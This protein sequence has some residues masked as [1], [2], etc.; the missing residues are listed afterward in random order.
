MN[1]KKISFIMC[2]NDDYYVRECYQYL[3]ELNVPTGYEVEICEIR[4]AR[5]MAAGYNEGM[6][7]TDAKY[8]V[9]LHQDVFIIHKNFLIDMLQLFQ[10]DVGI[11]MIGMVGTPYMFK[12]GVMWNGVRYGSFYRLREY[13]KKDITHRFFPMETGYMEMEAVDGLLIATQ[14]DLPWREDLFQKW[15]FYDASQSFEFIKEGYKVVVPGQDPEWYI[16]DCGAPNLTNYEGERRKFM[17]A[18]KDVM[19]SRQ[20]ETWESYLAHTRERLEQGFH[21]T[22]LEKT[23]ILK[24]LENLEDA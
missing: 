6:H 12:D 18:Y 14:Y 5:S 15:D 11:G 16:H 2:C 22:D 24:Y 3:E 7:G 17:E 19:D 21:G 20:Q 8:K 4:G 9:Y 10:T 13:V 23:K 1:D